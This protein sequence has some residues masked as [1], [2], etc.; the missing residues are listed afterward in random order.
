MANSIELAK[1]FLPILDEIYKAASK[2]ARMDALT[3]P[4]SFGAANEV[5]GFQNFNGWSWN[6]Q[7]F[8]WLPGG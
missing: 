6:L 8:G 2:T 4:V 1:K 3:K 5:K 7:P